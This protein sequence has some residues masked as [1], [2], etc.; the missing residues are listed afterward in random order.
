MQSGKTS[1]SALEHAHL[2]VPVFVRIMH[3]LH[4]LPTSIPNQYP[5]YHYL[6]GVCRTCSGTGW[7]AMIFPGI[8]VVGKV[9]PGCKGYAHYVRVKTRV[10]S[11]MLYLNA[12]GFK[13]LVT[14]IWGC[15][16]SMQLP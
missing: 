4:G 8:L 13:M 12:E 11:N 6:L 1:H 9:S 2:R 10:M 16:E 15:F 5:G 14:D 3:G 7:A